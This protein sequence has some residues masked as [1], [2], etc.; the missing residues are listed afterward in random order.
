[1]INVNKYNSIEAYNV[2]N[3][4]PAGESCVSLVVNSL[5]YE[6]KNV[7]KRENQL[8]EKEVCL[9][10]KDTV[11]GSIVYIPVYSFD[12]NTFDTTR[13][14]LKDY[15]R[16][17]ECIGEQLKVHKA[18]NGTAPYAAPNRYKITCDTT[19][20]GGFHWAITINGSAK[21]GDVAWDAND[22]LASIVAQ[23][24]AVANIASVVSGEDFIRIEVF[25]Y[26]NSTFTLSDN[27]GGTLVDLSVYVKIDGIAQEETHRTFQAQSVATLFPTLGFLAANS[28][29]YGKNGLN[30]T[31]YCGVNLT[32]YKSVYRTLASANVWAAENVGRMNE[33]TF[34]KCSD[35]TI[36]GADGIA[37]YNKYNG[38]WDAYMEAGMM[39]IDDTHTG[40]IEYLGYDN[41]ADQN[42]KLCSVTTMTFDGSYVPAYPAAA[43]AAADAFAD[44]DLGGV[45]HLPNPHELALMMEDETYEAIRYGQSFLTGA[46]LLSNTAYYW[47]VAEYY[48]NYA[49]LYYGGYGRLYNR[50]KQNS[51]TVRPVLA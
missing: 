29:N 49:W 42:A 7:L 37:L 26:S 2:D 45:A 34:D 5:V 17:G 39:N 48:S 18:N 23:I 33:A 4:R 30:M 27:T 9:I 41:G 10:A 8:G 13:Y 47:L 43:A 24:N 46:S 21:A 32:R 51:G 38:S 35:G 28:A 15:L 19:A 11:D 16:Y 6:G 25:S 20:S 40:G 50:Y 22:T 12:P 44:E 14:Q 3:D 36:G 31:Y 1:M